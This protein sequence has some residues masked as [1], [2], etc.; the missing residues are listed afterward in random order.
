MEILKMWNYSVR[1]SRWVARCS[2]S[3]RG[4]W[5][6]SLLLRHINKSM[7]GSTLLYLFPVL[8]ESIHFWRSGSGYL[9]M[10]LSYSCSTQTKLDRKLWR[11][12]HVSW[13]RGDVRLRH[14]KDAKTHQNSS[15]SMDQSYR[16]KYMGG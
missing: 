14:L 1:N 2:S 4:S 12:R 3:P 9:S 8:Q 16:G 15:S 13:V 10:S 7:E 6:H 11:K 5:M